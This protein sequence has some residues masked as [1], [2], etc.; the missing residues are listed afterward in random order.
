M[1]KILP[2]YDLP[3]HFKHEENHYHAFKHNYAS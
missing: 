1:I 2:L 3:N